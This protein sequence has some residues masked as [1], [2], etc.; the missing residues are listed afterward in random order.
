MYVFICIHAYK[1]KPGACMLHACMHTQL[2]CILSNMHRHKR[3]SKHSPS[4]IEYIDR[5]KNV[6]IRS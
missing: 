2:T 6:C 5:Y 1:H 4:Y 3:C